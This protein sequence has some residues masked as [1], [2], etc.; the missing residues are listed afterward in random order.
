MTCC[1]GA[2]LLHSQ[3]VVAVVHAR[4]GSARFPGKML[5][6]LGGYP[7]LEW[8][9]RRTLRA[10]GIDSFV[11]ATSDLSQDDALAA[12]GK[13]IGIPT[14]R[15]SHE[16]VLQRVID[17]ADSYKA[18]AVVRVCADN[19]FIDPELITALVSDFRR[20]SCD[21]LFNH[22]PGLGLD[23]ADGFGA[24]IFDMDV[25]RNI[26]KEFNEPRYREHLT[27]AIWEHSH[28]YSVRSLK[29]PAELSKKHVRFDVDTHE[30]L[31]FLESLVSN[32][33]LTMTSTATQILM[34][35]H[36]H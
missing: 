28:R 12:L 25:L 13:R 29:P 31:M 15:G 18:D 14:F 33:K 4:M 36:V 27:S 7:V 35:V 19:P 1:S 6:Q 16:N 8:V 32:G 20:E 10:D 11:L 3:Q 26:E 24:E 34:S 30:D 5:A 17:A 9:L 23:I 21:Y 2:I 22:R